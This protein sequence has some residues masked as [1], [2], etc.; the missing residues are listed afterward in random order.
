MASIIILL[1]IGL[2]AG[3]LSGMVGIGGG[4]I[5]VPA[6]VFFIGFSQHEAQGTTLAMFL[7]PIGILGVYNYYKAGYVDVKVALIMAITFVL[8]SYIGSK[9]SITLNQEVVKKVFGVIIFLIS[10]KMVFGK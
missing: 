6:L 3:L 7:I 9:V 4:I 1:C 10:L 8:G 2:A 5:I